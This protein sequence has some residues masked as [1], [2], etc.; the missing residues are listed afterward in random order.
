MVKWLVI[1]QL[2]TRHFVAIL[3]LVGQVLIKEEI[4]ISLLQEPPL[5]LE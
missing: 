5:A 3:D 4:D 1:A 2:N